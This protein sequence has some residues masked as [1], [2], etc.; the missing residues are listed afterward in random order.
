MYL[1]DIDENPLNDASF[2]SVDSKHKIIPIF[3]DL[4]LDEFHEKIYNYNQSFEC[5]LLTNLLE[6]TFRLIIDPVTYMSNGE[7]IQVDTSSYN[8]LTD[9]E[10]VFDERLAYKKL[11]K[12]FLE[13]F[14]EADEEDIRKEL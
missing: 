10:C 13:N 3:I 9:F 14:E 5:T 1:I 12:V 4:V 8:S 11:E 2:A 6:Q 7:I